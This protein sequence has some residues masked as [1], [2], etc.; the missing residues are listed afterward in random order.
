MVASL[1]R[2]GGLLPTKEAEP[3]NVE[4]ILLPQRAMQVLPMRVGPFAFRYKGTEL[5]LANILI[6]LERQLIAL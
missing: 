6:P 5:P 1:S 4:E 2:S 3:G